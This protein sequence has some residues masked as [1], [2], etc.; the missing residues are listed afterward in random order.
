MPGTL[1]ISTLS[2][3]AGNSTSATNAIVGSAKA[4][5]N[6]NGA[7]GAI[8]ASSNV[9]SV[10]RSAAGVYVVNFAVAFADTNYAW[11]VGGLRVAAGDINFLI[12]S[13]QQNTNNLAI[14]TCYAYSSPGT[15]YDMS[16]VNV[17]VFR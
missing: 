13:N 16:V 12:G 3:G 7:S 9:S 10:T 14:S 8:R 4:W 1:V 2:D 5:V 11:A 17:A 6:F 15:F